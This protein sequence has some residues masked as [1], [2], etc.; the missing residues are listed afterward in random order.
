MGFSGRVDLIGVLLLGVICLG[1]CQTTAVKPQ[2]P[3]ASMSSAETLSESQSSF[4]SPD[5]ERTYSGRE[6]YGEAVYREVEES[7]T[8]LMRTYAD[9]NR[10]IWGVGAS[11]DPETDLRIGD[12]IYYQIPDEE[13]TDPQQVYD[14]A[15]ETVTDTFFVENYQPAVDGEFLIGHEGK[16]YHISGVIPGRYGWPV[17]DYRLLSYASEQELLAAFE[18]GEGGYDLFRFVWEDGR[19]KI[20]RFNSIYF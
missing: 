1:G 19:W 13:M 18:T 11:S 8:T 9:V 7:L 4:V 20:D 16:L 17:E 15:R 14:L 3:S 6:V 2:P 10:L 5:R 12:T